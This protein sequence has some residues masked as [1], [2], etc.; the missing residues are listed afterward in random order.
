MYLQSV[1]SRF[2]Y[3]KNCLYCLSIYLYSAKY[4]DL[5]FEVGHKVIFTGSYQGLLR[6]LLKAPVTVL[7]AY[8]CL[9]NE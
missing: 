4:Y 9:A 7:T 5:V 8:S 6:M 1:N 2:I 3:V